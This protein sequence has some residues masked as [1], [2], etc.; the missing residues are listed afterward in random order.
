MAELYNPDSMPSELLAAHQELDIAVDK[1]YREKPFKDT[2]DRLS[3]LL[4]RYEEMVA[5]QEQ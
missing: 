3:C 4:A 5:K 2:A 1:L